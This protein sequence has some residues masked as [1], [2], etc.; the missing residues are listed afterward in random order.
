MELSA[1]RTVL[2]KSEGYLILVRHGERLDDSNRVSPEERKATKMLNELDTP[3]SINGK[4]MAVETGQHIKAFLNE[5]GHR[6]YNVKMISSPYVRCLQTAEGIFRGMEESI[7]KITVREELSEMQIG[8]YNN[9][10]Q[11]SDLVVNQFL[12]NEE[13]FLKEYLGT[14]PEHTELFYDRNYEAK[15]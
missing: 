10:A 14:S 6:D 11:I 1:N 8:S 5:N 9:E 3:L 13:N 2:G 4:V 12:G 15:T 7:K